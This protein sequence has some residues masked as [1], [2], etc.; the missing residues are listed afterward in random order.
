MCHQ[1]LFSGSNLL[2]SYF[3]MGFLNGCNLI[4]VLEFRQ[5]ELANLENRKKISFSLFIYLL[6][7]FDMLLIRCFII[8]QTA[9]F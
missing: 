3:Q 2:A 7:F 4:I 1:K 5:F 9:V 6:D 8:I